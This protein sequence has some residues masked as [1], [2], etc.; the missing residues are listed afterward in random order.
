MFIDSHSHIYYDTFNNDIEDIIEDAFQLGVKKII[1]VGVDLKSSESCIDLA[2][3]FKN[4]Y[5]TVGFH[6]HESKLAGPDYLNILES[7]TKHPKVIAIGEIGLDFH[8]NHSEIKIQKKIFH[9]QLELA[10]SI[11]LPTVVHSRN[12][13]KETYDTISKVE[14]SK[15]V[16]HCFASGIE[17]AKK[18]IKLNYYI[19]FTGLITFAK[20]LESVVE[21]IPLNHMLIETDSPYLSPIPFRGKRNEP[22]NVIEVAK[23]I[24]KIKNIDLADVEKITSENTLKLFNKIENG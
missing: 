19:S 12:A 3:K 2:D 14:K 20:E 17:Q 18:I 10:E 23:K 4:I 22:K 7:F 8:Y 1:C 24:S 5:A 9:E 13:D 21:N 11:N 15:G 16:V 6:P